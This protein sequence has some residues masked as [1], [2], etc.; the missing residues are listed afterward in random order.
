[1]N[2]NITDVRESYNGAS[3]FANDANYEVQRSN[4]FEIVIDLAAIGLGVEDANSSDSY[5]TAIRLCCTSAP[6]PSIQIN[7][8]QLRH[9]NEL[10]NVAGSP[11]WNEINISVYD[12]IGRDMAGLLQ[13]WFWRVFDPNTHTMGLVVS[14]KT[15]ATIYEYSP[16]ASVIRAWTVFG[17]FPTRL[18]FGQM[19]A[20]GQGEPVTIQMTLAVDKSVQRVVRA[21]KSNI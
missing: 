1:M 2:N 12:V 18:E 9:G 7:P 5:Q 14:Y 11:Q 3:H 6:I 4:H 13:Q 20:N 16:D 19:Q 17:V 10:I 21:E 8:Q 15:T